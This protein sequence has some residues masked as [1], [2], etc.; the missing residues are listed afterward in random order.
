MSSEPDRLGKY[1]ILEPLGAGSMGVVYLAYDPVIERKVAIKTIRKHEF[2]GSAS[3]EAT[4]RFRREATAAGKLSHP[5]IVGIYDFGEDEANGYIVMEYAPGM[6]LA[7]YAAS[8]SLSLHEVGRL[9]GELLDALGHAHAAGIVH[10]DIKPANLLVADQLKI[11]D[12]GIA[13][14]RDSKLTQVGAAMGTPSYMAPEQYMGVAVDHRVDLFAAGVI[15]YELLTGRLPFEGS[16][17]VE[18][19]YKICHTD[20]PPPSLVRPGLPPHLDAVVARA[21]AKDPGARFQSAAEFATA[22]A[23]TPSGNVA[24]DNPE[25]LREPRAPASGSPP[26]AGLL[27]TDTLRR[28][29]AALAPALGLVAGAALKRALARAR[30]REELVALLTDPVSDAKTREG[31]LTTLRALLAAPLEQAATERLSAAPNSLRPTAAIS[32]ADL[33]RVTEVLALRVGPIAK[34]MVKKAAADAASYRDLCLG[35]SA[36][37]GTDAERESF[38]RELGAAR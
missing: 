22:L 30:T 10:R 14:V 6:D 33:A 36:K 35:L 2:G 25:S 27:S 15:L 29:D 17:V 7:K 38:L 28:V 19:S 34:I 32:A 37:L 24:R 1:L 20:P 16:S 3:E 21:L 26:A 8:R 31:L 4:E 18:V 5:G 23:V 13:R 11:T 12:F 9:L